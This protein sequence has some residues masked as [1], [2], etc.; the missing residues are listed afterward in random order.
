[1]YILPKEIRQ[2]VNQLTHRMALRFEYEKRCDI[3]AQLKDM[4]E[5]GAT[6]RDLTHALAKMAKQPLG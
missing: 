1:M 4:V 5:A 3:L 2:E 6:E